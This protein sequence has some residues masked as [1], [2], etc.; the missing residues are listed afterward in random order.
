MPSDVLRQGP[1]LPR[2]NQEGI[3]KEGNLGRS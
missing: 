1:E 3:L 2:V